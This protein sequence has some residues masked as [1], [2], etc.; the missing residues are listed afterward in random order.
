[1]E[2]NNVEEVTR[3]EEE[4]RENDTLSSPRST[5]TRLHSRIPGES[6][7]LAVRQSYKQAGAD[8]QMEF[9]EIVLQCK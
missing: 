9:G 7:S 8:E 5:T 4:E 2:F 3:H 6:T 1:M